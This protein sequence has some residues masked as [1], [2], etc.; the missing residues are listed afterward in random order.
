M[1][2]S[3]IVIVALAGILATYVVCFELMETTKNSNLALNA[4]QQVLEEMRSVAFTSIYSIYNGHT[5]FVPALGA[6][7]NLGRVYINNSNPGL[8][9]VTVGVC[10]RQKSQ[11]IIGECRVNGTVLTFNDTNANNILDSPVQMTTLMAQR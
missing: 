4:A 2:V 7:N 6:N 9:N 10:W 11:R 5:F 8:L 1:I 3:G